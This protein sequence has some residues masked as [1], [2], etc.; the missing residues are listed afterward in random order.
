MRKIVNRAVAASRLATAVCILG[1]V[2]GYPLYAVPSDSLSQAIVAYGFLRS[3]YQ[4]FDQLLEDASAKTAMQDLMALHGSLESLRCDVPSRLAFPHRAL[5]VPI[6]SRAFWLRAAAPS[7]Q[8]DGSLFAIGPLG[9]TPERV[10][11]VF[12]S[13]APD[14]TTV[15]WLERDRQG[16]MT[17]LVYDSFNKGDVGNAPAT[18]IGAVNAVRIESDN[19]ILLEEGAEPGTGPGGRVTGRVFELRVTG[20]ITAVSLRGAPLSR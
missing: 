4:D 3:S 17:R 10:L 11:I 2:N 14:E 18:R 1:L 5:I 15:F 6:S 7:A 20:T 8:R 13:V 19:E 12:S 16:Y 9:A